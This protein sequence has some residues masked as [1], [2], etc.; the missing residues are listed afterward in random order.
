MDMRDP[1]RPDRVKT[2]TTAELGDELLIRTVF[3]DGEL[4][5]TY[6]HIDRVMAHVRLLDAFNPIRAD[7]L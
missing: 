3:V 7:F 4:T 5:L 6:S 1:S 2:F